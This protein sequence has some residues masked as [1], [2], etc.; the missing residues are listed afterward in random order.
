MEEAASSRSACARMMRCMLALQPYSPVVSTHG[1]SSARLP[2]TTCHA[3][4]TTYSKYL[5][6]ET[7]DAYALHVTHK[8]I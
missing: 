2:T 7:A 3:H 4:D 6:V 8:H 5:N 1:D